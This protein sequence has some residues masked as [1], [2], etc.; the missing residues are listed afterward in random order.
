MLIAVHENTN[1]TQTYLKQTF[2]TRSSWVRLK[3]WIMLFEEH[4][5]ANSK[6]TYL[7]NTF[8]IVYL[9]QWM[10]LIEVL[11]NANSKQA[12]L[13]HTFSTP[14]LWIWLKQWIMLFEVHENTVQNK[15]TGNIPFRHSH[16]DYNW[17]NE[18]CFLKYMKMQ[19]QNK[20]TFSAP[21]L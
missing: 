6:Q 1:S 17:N 9:K 4:E 5:N 10:M 11:E 3:Q 14:S 15:H 7:F 13:K 19:I 16:Y 2:A 20:H 18:L 8:I 12:Y 21:S